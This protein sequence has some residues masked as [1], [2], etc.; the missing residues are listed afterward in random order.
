MPLERADIVHRTR[1]ADGTPAGALV[2]MHGRGADELDLAPLVDL[3]DPDRR[4]VG[5][6]PRGPLALPPGG[7]HWYVV[8]HI[9]YPDA[10]T[11]L[12]TFD[13]ASDWADAALEEAGLE[14]GRTVFGGFSQGTVMS[15]ALGLAASR[16]RPAGIIAMSGFI[17]RVDGFELDLESRSGLPVSISHGTHDPVIGVEWGRDARER[18][19][20]AGAE[21]SYREDPVAHQI[22]QAALTQ[23]RA[24]VESAFG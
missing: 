20:A 15:Y 18:L 19:G 7:A 8:R 5:L 4:L 21:V 6:L 23:A 16:P 17:P 13:Q 11:F 9:G 2:L 22:A 14:P 1:P 10:P 24:V 3:L 12:E